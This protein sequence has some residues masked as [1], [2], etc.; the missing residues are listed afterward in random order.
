MTS[1]TELTQPPAL[2]QPQAQV[3]PQAH[4][5]PKT[6]TE[7]LIIERLGQGWK[8]VEVARNLGVDE[9]YVAQI[10]GDPD[11]AEEIRSKLAAVAEEHTKFDG[12]LDRTE[13]QFLMNIER[14]AKMSN[15]KESLMAFKILNS[16]KR[17]RDTMQ[18][19]KQETGVTV[20]IT[21]PVS[22]S[23][24][25][26]TNAQSEIV[27]V[28]GRTMVSARPGQLEQIMKDRLGREPTAKVEVISQ[29]RKDRAEATLA[30]LDRKAPRRRIPL[31][32]LDISDVS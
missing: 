24:S 30:T 12:T 20:N 11:N 31:D 22:A 17:R 1:L 32:K 21:L 13:E 4:Q 18:A 28:E 5:S 9:S 26:L 3:Q 6:R 23:V 29:E 19:P 25:Y 8:Q 14:R 2:A 10:A 16:A 15:M 27:E 7:Q